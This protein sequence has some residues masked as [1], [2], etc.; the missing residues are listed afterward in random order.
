M[1]GAQ[2][3]S[4]AARADRLRRAVASV[5]GFELRAHDD[6]TYQIAR[7]SEL[8]GSAL[9]FDDDMTLHGVELWINDVPKGKHWQ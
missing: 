2:E 5:T 3:D 4:E 1:S 7:M 8:T 6:V 9:P